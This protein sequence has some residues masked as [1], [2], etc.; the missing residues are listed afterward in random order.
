METQGVYHSGAKA[1]RKGILDEDCCG[2]ASEHS[3]IRISPINAV[4]KAGNLW[5]PGRFYATPVDQV[6][7]VSALPHWAN[8]SVCPGEAGRPVGRWELQIEP[9]AARIVREARFYADAAPQVIYCQM[10]NR[11]IRGRL[12]AQF[13]GIFRE[14][15]RSGAVAGEGTILPC[16]IVAQMGGYSVLGG[17]H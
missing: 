17:S 11:G 12:K 15:W 14:F 4:I 2:F 8:R 3:V 7:G 16:Q 6:M 9:T 5:S 13:A 10:R 1:G